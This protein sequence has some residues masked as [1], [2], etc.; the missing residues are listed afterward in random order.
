M[1]TTHFHDLSTERRRLAS[2]RSGRFG[3]QTNCL[4]INTTTEFR[5][6]SRFQVQQIVRGVGKG[7]PGVNA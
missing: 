7:R 5:V 2:L 4:F 6:K 1:C 3:S